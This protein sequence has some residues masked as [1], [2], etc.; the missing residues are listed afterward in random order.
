MPSTIPTNP[1]QPTYVYNVDI[2]GVYNRL[3]RFIVEVFR[4]VSANVSMMSTF[5]Q[6][7]LQSYITNLNGYL[8]WVTAQPNLDL[9][10]TSP[11]AYAL[12]PLA[13]RA[14]TENEE[15]NDVINHLELMRDELIN[16]QS[17]RLGSGLIKFDMGRLGAALVKTEAFLT[18][19]IANLTPLDLPESSP[20]DPIVPGGNTGV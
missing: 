3:N 2:V 4:S 1:P 7:R 6:Q 5:D 17:A 13:T 11:R 8:I 9:P 18:T 12:E 15:A 14:D 16:S 19:Y 20:Q 10:E